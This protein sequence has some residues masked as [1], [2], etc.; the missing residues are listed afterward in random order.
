MPD[1]YDPNL[2]PLDSVKTGFNYEWMRQLSGG[3]ERSCFPMPETVT[4]FRT[5]DVSG[6]G[7][8]KQRQY[9]IGHAD[10]CGLWLW[11]C[12]VHGQICGYHIMPHGEG[13]RDCLLSLLRFK[14]DPPEAVW[15]DFGCQAEETGLNWA[16]EYFKQVCW[17]IDRF[18]NYGHKCSPRMSSAN[19]DGMSSTNTSLMEQVNSFLQS[20]RGL[21]KSG[22]TKVCT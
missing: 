20:I 21:L 3:Y 4:G 7:C 1:T 13:R 14:L 10:R 22:T 11:T 18:H 17:Y 8:Q 6:D 15:V 5:T 19:L 9:V 2:A 12:M 16:P